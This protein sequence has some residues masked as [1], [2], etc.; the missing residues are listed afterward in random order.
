MSETTTTTNASPN[1]PTW[2][3]NSVSYEP[4]KPRGR[5]Q[6]C[7][8]HRYGA[9]NFWSVKALQGI[10][11]LIGVVML[12]VSAAR[13][14]DSSGAEIFAVAMGYAAV[15]EIAYQFIIHQ[16]RAKLAAAGVDPAPKA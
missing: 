5:H 7:A 13:S 1:D 12:I 10:S 6:S 8:D 9:V 2:V 15:L 11:L 3:L 14:D 4:T 16:C